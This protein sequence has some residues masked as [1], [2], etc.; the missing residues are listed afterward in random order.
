M[1]TLWLLI[2]G[3]LIVAL[4]VFLRNVR[5]TAPAVTWSDIPDVIA[6][7]SSSGGHGHFAAFMFAA[8]GMAPPPDDSLSIQVSID[9]GVMGIDWLLISKLNLDAEP[10]FREFFERKGLRAI[11]RE[12][13]GVEY[14][15][16]EGGGL[17]VLTQEFL[18][19]SF[20]VKPDQRMDLIAEGF[21]WSS[22][23]SRT[24]SAT[25]R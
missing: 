2:G 11:A 8:D 20:G 6:A 16:V 10:R 25:A 14:L 1:N 22:G 21:T 19:E 15:R 18:A 23:S 5:R 24:R 9:N 4:I 12:A 3:V 17:A 7:L 13:N